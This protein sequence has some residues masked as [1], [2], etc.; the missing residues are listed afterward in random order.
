[1]SAELSLARPDVR[2][3][4]RWTR[5]QAA[6]NHAIWL[7]AR[8]ALGLAS[9]LPASALRRAGALAGSVASRAWRSARR[10]ADRN[11]SLALP[12]LGDE[13]RRAIAHACF[14]ELGAHL[15]EALAVALGAAP[16]PLVVDDAARRTLEDAR[17]EGRGVVL[18][19]A[20]LGPWERVAAGLVAAGVPLVTLVRGSYD[21]RFDALYD[22]LR[23]SAGVRTLYRG[24]PGTAAR[25]VRTLRRGEV[26][27]APMDLKTRTP[28]VTVPL[29]GAPAETPLGPARIA[30]RTGAAVVVATAERVRGEL[31]VTA[32]RLDVRGLD[33]GPD[34]VRRLTAAINDE[35]GRRIRALP[36]AWPWMHARW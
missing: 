31:R 34:G 23:G 29:L 28:S 24:A 33:A 11:L 5:A 26:L 10:T 30:L 4:Q 15:G 2:L 21:P 8:S 35:L 20:H 7:A 17:A 18:P 1:V 16:S 25:I 19:S 12:E 9:W 3:G 22:R 14:A 13:E 36:E 27:G 6:K 32:T